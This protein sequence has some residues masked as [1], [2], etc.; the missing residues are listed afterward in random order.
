MEE[1]RTGIAMVEMVRKE[2]APDT[3]WNR[4]ETALDEQTAPSRPSSLILPAR[5][6]VWL[7]AVVLAVPAAC[8]LAAFVLLRA[9]QH[10]VINPLPA[11]PSWQVASVSGTPMV[12]AKKVGKS[13]RL[14]I[15]EE[16]VTD[17]VSQANLDI[18]NIGHVV[19]EPNSRL[20][21]VATRPNEH[22][23]ALQQGRMSAEIKAPP[24]LFFVDTPSAVAVD[25]GCAY[26]LT[27][28]AQKESLLHVTF[29][30]VSFEKD[31]REVTVFADTRCKTVPGIGPGTPWFDDAPS[32]LVQALEQ[33][34]F[35][36]GGNAALKSVLAAARPKDSFTLINLL[37]HTQGAQRE[38][39]YVS[40]AK[41]V[42]LPAGVT[43][44]GLLR[45]EPTMLTEWQNVMKPLWDDVVIMPK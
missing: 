35:R 32:A 41:L 20:K 24:R 28:N 5:R 43:K 11:G 18:A 39:V 31:G 14:H 9:N 1:I 22:R 40:L 36:N 33:F 15:G 21:L 23:I 4:I 34:D 6:P 12:G 2:A 29:G 27:V 44:E 10:P 13:G 16:L 42:E 17:G 45:L 38:R 3:L 8:A 26:T 30:R 37:Q 19:L 7:R 25:L